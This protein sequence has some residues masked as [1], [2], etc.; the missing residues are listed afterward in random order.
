SR[1]TSGRRR[2]QERFCRNGKL[3]MG[4]SAALLKQSTSTNNVS[5][6]CYPG[7]T[8]FLGF[9]NV[10]R[11]SLHPIYLPKQK[12]RCSAR[13]GAAPLMPAIK[14]SPALAALLGKVFAYPTEVSLRELFE[15]FALADENGILGQVQ[16]VAELCGELGF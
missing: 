8:V 9:G 16:E 11:A 2:T 7:L 12:S 1:I 10:G 4:K 13:P 3:L 14:T 5:I 6:S 15:T